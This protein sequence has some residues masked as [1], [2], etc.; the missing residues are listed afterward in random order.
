MV[1]LFA[2]FSVCPSVGHPS[3]AQTLCSHRCVERRTAERTSYN[4]TPAAAN[5]QQTHKTKGHLLI[6][7]SAFLPFSFMSFFLPT[8]SVREG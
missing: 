1:L 4:V 7:H 5:P 2:Q 3:P 8:V 6:S